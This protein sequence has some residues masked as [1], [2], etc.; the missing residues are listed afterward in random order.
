MSMSVQDQTY[1]GVALRLR[2]E[3]HY[4]ASNKALLSL[5]RRYPTYAFL[6]Y[7]TAWS[8]DLLGKPA[9]AIGYYERAIQ[10]GLT[11]DDLAGALLGL[12]SSYRALGR[13]R[14]AYDAFAQGVATFPDDH[15]L[16][17]FL[18][19]AAHDRGDHALSVRLLVE[20]LL[21]TTRDPQLQRHASALAR[22]AIT[23]TEPP[24]QAT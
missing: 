18:A 24:A 5:Y 12:G 1:F 14:A 9:E 2:R 10:L 13:N 19:L 7:H 15:A 20:L 22:Y 16:N 4:V 23:L 6:A 8:F 3:Q 21:A 11:E 17:A